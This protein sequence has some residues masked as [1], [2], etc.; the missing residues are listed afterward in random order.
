MPRIDDINVL[1]G[2]QSLILSNFSLLLCLI[3]VLTPY[4]DQVRAVHGPLYPCHEFSVIVSRLNINGTSIQHVEYTAQ[5]IVYLDFGG[6]KLLAEGA[7]APSNQS[8]MEMLLQRCQEEVNDVT[9]KMG[10]GW[11]W[12]GFKGRS[13]ED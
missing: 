1:L 3:P 10:V 2:L 4:P 6:W 7:P 11:I 13:D 8:A 9:E 5:A 12:D